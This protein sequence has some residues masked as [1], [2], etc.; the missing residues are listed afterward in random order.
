M[1]SATCRSATTADSAAIAQLVNAAYRPAGE[2]GWRH[3]SGLLSGDRTRD[4]QV[5]QRLSS[6]H[7][8]ILVEQ[9]GPEVVACV[10]RRM[11]GDDCW[12]GL[13]AIKPDRQGSGTGGDMLALAEK[14]AVSAFSARRL[15]VVVVTARK[16]LMDYY[17]RRGYRK[18]GFPE[19]HP[20]SAGT[21][22]PRS[23]GL[24]IETLAK[25]VSDVR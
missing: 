2:P 15:L 18:A 14:Y 4:L 25:A 7:A 22:T 3:E 5:D 10:H 20:G 21:G 16:A 24:K 11:A 12:I 8:V 17:L 19:D 13:L 6:P 23:T 9:R 1:S